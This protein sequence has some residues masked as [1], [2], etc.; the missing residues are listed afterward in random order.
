MKLY[1]HLPSP[2]GTV[3]VTS[4][5]GILTRLYLDCD[6]SPDGEGWIED[7]GPFS[8]VAEQLDA[9]WRGELTT[10]DVPMDPRG[11]EFQKQVWT[12]LTEIPYGETVTYGEIADALGKPRAVRAV[13]R[14]NGSNPIAVI[15]PCHR[16][17]GANGSL[18]G[19]AGGL[20][21]KERLLNLEKRTVGNTV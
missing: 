7:P 10:F 15:V 2:L 17:I 18:T 16:V 14:A 19:Y 12:A 5:N 20:E 8:A 13:G 9:Y 3:L 4:E 1:A 6:E 11:T 21:K